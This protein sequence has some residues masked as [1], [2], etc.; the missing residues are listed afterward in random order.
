MFSKGLYIC[1]A[2][3][4]VSP[5]AGDVI[6]MPSDF[7]EVMNMNVNPSTSLYEMEEFH[8]ESLREIKRM[9]SDDSYSDS[10]VVADHIMF[11]EHLLEKLQE[12]LS[13]EQKLGESAIHLRRDM[14]DINRLLNAL[15]ELKD[16]L[17]DA[18]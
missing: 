5:F 13:N 3:Y 16:N 18:G 6:G 2:Y 7:D 12:I 9:L 15:Y 17:L 8:R 11:L 1:F 4:V 10:Q 14:S